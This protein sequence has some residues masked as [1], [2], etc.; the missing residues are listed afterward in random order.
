MNPVDKE[1]LLKP[2][3]PFNKI[4][5]YIVAH[6]DDWQLFMCPGVYNDLVSPGSKVVFIITTAGDAGM[7]EKFW[8]AREE[9]LKSSIRFCVAPFSTKVEVVGEREFNSHKISYCEINDTTTYFLRLPDGN[10]DGAGFSACSFKTLSQFKSGQ[11]NAV[12]A[13]NNSATYQ[14]WLEL[15]SLLESIVAF[16]RNGFSNTWVHY[17]NPDV[18]MNPNDHPDHMATG[19]IIQNMASIN[20]VHQ[21]LFAGYSTIAQGDTL[22][23]PD[24]FWKAG[25]FAA[26]EKGVYDNCGYSTLAENPEL[27]LKLC[28][29]SPTFSSVP[30]AFKKGFFQK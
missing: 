12:S 7:G 25:M 17:I 11:I 18:L 24:L 27:Y 2:V 30:P 9:G 5:F 3:L 8:L 29:R 10:L 14:S 13:I 15:V 23:S 6:A 21:L 1:Q 28:C 26:Y 22:T 19:D 16:E 4:A 20:C